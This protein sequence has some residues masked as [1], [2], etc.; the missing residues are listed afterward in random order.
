MNG[1]VEIQSLIFTFCSVSWYVSG[2][3]ELVSDNNFWSEC[4]RDFDYKVGFDLSHILKNY[5][6]D[7]SLRFYKTTSD[8]SK[9]NFE[10][11]RISTKICP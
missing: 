5:M 11:K 8:S 9:M 7:I 2:I 4:Y 10:H 6:H 1:L 3:H